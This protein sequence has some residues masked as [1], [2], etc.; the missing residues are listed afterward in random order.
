ML[1]KNERMKVWIKHE[2]DKLCPICKLRFIHHSISLWWK[3]LCFAHFWTFLQE[4]RGSPQWTSISSFS[5]F[6]FL[7]SR[8]C[9]RNQRR[10]SRRSWGLLGC[11]STSLPTLA[12]IHSFVAGGFWGAPGLI[13]GVMEQGALWKQQI[14]ANF[15]EFLH[16]I[17]GK[18]RPFSVFELKPSLRCR[19]FNMQKLC[20]MQ[21]LDENSQR[22]QELKFCI[23][24][25]VDCWCLI[26]IFICTWRHLRFENPYTYICTDT[27]TV[28]CFLVWMTCFDLIHF[29]SCFNESYYKKAKDKEPTL[30]LGFP[31][32]SLRHQ[33]GVRMTEWRKFR[34]IEAG[35]IRALKA[36]LWMFRR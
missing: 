10:W 13:H 1:Q 2:I 12:E 17:H 20:G 35:E 15:D 16:Q 34:T 6:R 14:H 24:K 11:D 32:V 30:H 29:D 33:P 26:F 22:P 4:R 31:M 19:L 18:P 21:R 9:S 7:L 5:L 3:F 25:I 8:L 28:I 36:Y 27:S 23:D